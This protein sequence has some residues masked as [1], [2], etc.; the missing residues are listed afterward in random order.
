MAPRL[1]MKR[2]PRR[3]QT[4]PDLGRNLV[5]AFCRTMARE[6]SGTSGARPHYLYVSR[7]LAR[8]AVRP[9]A[10]LA[11]P[12]HRSLNVR[13]RALFARATSLVCRLRCRHQC[14]HRLRF[15]SVRASRRRLA[16]RRHGKWHVSR[17]ALVVCR[18]PLDRPR[19]S[20]NEGGGGG[21]G[22]CCRIRQLFVARRVAASPPPSLQSPEQPPLPQRSRG[23]P[24]RLAE[25]DPAA[26]RRQAGSGSGVGTCLR[27]MLGRPLRFRPRHFRSYHLRSP[28]SRLACRPRCRLLAVPSL[29]RSRAR[30]H[31]YTPSYTPGRLP[32]SGACGA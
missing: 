21:G 14:Q 27:L 24:S 15:R 22:F 10:P 32:A 4:R 25:P 17:R 29:R 26:P 19:C 16:S 1:V 9:A 13:A 8:R 28:C 23:A 5:N 31:T 20:N 3:L 6:A 12:R 11:D 18:P 7:S 30:L 2:V